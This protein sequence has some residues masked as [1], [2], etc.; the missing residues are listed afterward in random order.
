MRKIHVQKLIWRRELYMFLFLFNGFCNRFGNDKNLMEHK[1]E[2]RP[3]IAASIY[4]F[5][6]V[7]FISNVAFINV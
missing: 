6:D 5:F 1:I 4:N 2:V 7:T 3:I